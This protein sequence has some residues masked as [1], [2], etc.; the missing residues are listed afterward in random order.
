MK[1][2]IAVF[3]NNSSDWDRIE[4]GRWD[5]APSPSDAVT[6]RDALEIGDMAEPLGFDGIWCPDHFGTPYGMSPNPLQVLTYFAGRTSRITLVPTNTLELLEAA[7][8]RNA[9]K[10]GR[11][12]KRPDQQAIAAISQNTTTDELASSLISS[13]SA[14]TNS[15][16]AS[17]VATPKFM[18]ALY[19]NANSPVNDGSEEDTQL[20]IANANP[21]KAVTSLAAVQLPQFPPL[22]RR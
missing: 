3:A 6:V 8:A 12:E 2:N 14:V 18:Q 13:S 20:A 19:G 1:V 11:I 16:M 4:A 22:P 7:A 17:T 21:R 15:T 9:A 5:E 10:A